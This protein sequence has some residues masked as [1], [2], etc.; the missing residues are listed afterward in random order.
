MDME[1]ETPKT[2]ERPIH[3]LKD[4]KAG[5]NSVQLIVSTLDHVYDADTVE[6]GEHSWQVIGS[7]HEASV[8]EL[9]KCLSTRQ[10][11]GTQNRSGSSQDAGKRGFGGVGR[12]LEESG[13]Q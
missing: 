1:S 3:R 11:M 2:T 6:A 4:I 8:A 10:A 9:A 12:R 7:W 13:A 5:G